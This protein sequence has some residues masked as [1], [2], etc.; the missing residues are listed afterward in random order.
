MGRG[1]F[2]RPRKVDV[3]DE[4]LQVVPKYMISRATKL[5]RGGRTLRSEIDWS[6]VKYFRL[7]LLK[8]L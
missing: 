4:V 3:P 6:T 8:V 2:L 7:F 1:R 5:S